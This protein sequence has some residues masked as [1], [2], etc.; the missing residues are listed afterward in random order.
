MNGSERNPDASDRAH[1]QMVQR[2]AASQQMLTAYIRSL[3]MDFDAADDI[4]QETNVVLWRRAGDYDPS[5]RFTTWACG[6]AYHQVLAHLRDRRRDA[7]QLI[8]EDLLQD[9][10]A[11]AQT[12]AQLMDDRLHALKHC[13]G[14]LTDHQRQLI[15]SRY[16][17][18]GSVQQAA[19]ERNR[20]AAALSVQLSRI[21]RKLHDC[22]NAVMRTQPS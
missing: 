13:M 6:I 2:I 11:R 5:T 17:P 21:R 1:E 10:A 4:L 16:H 3:V 19:A 20:S 18:G 9:L 22:I 7:L 8:G 15:R 12:Q 14:K